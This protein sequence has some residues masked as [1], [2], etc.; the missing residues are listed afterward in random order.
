MSHR[1]LR[2]QDKSGFRQRFKLT[3]QTLMTVFMIKKTFGYR[4]KRCSF[5]TESTVAYTFTDE[6][7]RQ[8]QFEIDLK[9]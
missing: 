4:P 2:N 3:N 6:R 7:T 5:F 9:N 8:N 1:N